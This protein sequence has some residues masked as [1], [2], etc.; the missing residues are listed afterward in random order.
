MLSSSPD[1]DLQCAIQRPAV[2]DGK[3][4][5]EHGADTGRQRHSKDTRPLEYDRQ[6]FWLAWIDLR[7][8]SL[9]IPRLALGQVQRLEFPDSGTNFTHKYVHIDLQQGQ[10]FWVSLRTRNQHAGAHVFA[11]SG[12]HLNGSDKGGIDR[13]VPS[14]EQA[15]SDLASLI[16]PQL[17]AYIPE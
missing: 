12:K 2:V 17:P 6:V 9:P 7:M 1:N 11:P 10:E 14:A 16:I 15:F 5:A 13:D 8:D 4:L 3:E